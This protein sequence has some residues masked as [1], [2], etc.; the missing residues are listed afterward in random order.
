M[1]VPLNYITDPKCWVCTFIFGF[2]IFF[3]IECTK[4][5]FYIYIEVIGMT[6]I[7]EEVTQIDFDPNELFYF[8]FD[9]K[10][11]DFQPWTSIQKKSIFFVIFFVLF[12]FIRCG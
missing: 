6:I 5:A 9:I 4:M 3:S 11:S 1:H 12:R 10:M 8:I 7:I 2:F